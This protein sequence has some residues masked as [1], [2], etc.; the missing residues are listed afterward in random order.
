MSTSTLGRKP[1]H[2]A[3][4]NELANHLTWGTRWKIPHFK[5]ESLGLK[6]LEAIEHERRRMKLDIY[7]FALMPDHFHIIIGPYPKRVGYVVQALKLASVH[8]LLR[9]ELTGGGLWQRG[10]YD[11]AMR[12]LRQLRTVMEYVHNNPVKLGLVEDPRQY[13]LSS[14]ADWAGTTESPIRLSSS[15][16]FF[17]L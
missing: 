17:A 8:R 7:A 6:C 3:D 15:H 13:P 10:Y 16:L 2:P 5:D 4:A 1:A 14:C 11:V 12:D 9:E